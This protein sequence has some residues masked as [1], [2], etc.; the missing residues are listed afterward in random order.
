MKSFIVI[1]S[2]YNLAMNFLVAQISADPYCFKIETDI[3]EANATI[4]RL[5][6]GNKWIGDHVSMKYFTKENIRRLGSLIENERLK[7]S[8]V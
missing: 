6:P 4:L 2:I 8:L 7:W 5:L 1:I 3:H